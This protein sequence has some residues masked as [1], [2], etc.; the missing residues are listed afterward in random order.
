[1]STVYR[2][3]AIPADYK[4]R[5]WKET[6][7]TLKPNSKL[8]VAHLIAHGTEHAQSSPDQVA[9]DA[10]ESKKL[11]GVAHRY[12]VDVSN[13]NTDMAY[14]FQFDVNDDNQTRMVHIWEKRLADRMAYN[15]LRWL[16]NTA[17]GNFF[18][19]HDWFDAKN[20]LHIKQLVSRRIS[21]TAPY[22][23]TRRH[24]PGRTRYS[25]KLAPW[26]GVDVSPSSRKVRK[27]VT[28]RK[29]RRRSPK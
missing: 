12:V 4:W 1:M 6:E 9:T 5:I 23:A 25:P 19:I 8:T 24:T 11:G 18:A 28:P 21:R 27:T 22:H 29:T 17:T 10:F 14:A 7:F 13:V 3:P 2:T 15:N 20:K 26:G 16:V